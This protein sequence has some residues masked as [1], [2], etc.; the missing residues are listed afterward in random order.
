MEHTNVPLIVVTEAPETPPSVP[1]SAIVIATKLR[2]TAD[3]IYAIFQDFDV[4][5]IRE[6][7]KLMIHNGEFFRMLVEL[8]SNHDTEKAIAIYHLR[9]IERLSVPPFSPDKRVQMILYRT[10]DSQQLRQANIGTVQKQFFPPTE[11]EDDSDS[12]LYDLVV[13]QI[14]NASLVYFHRS[15]RSVVVHFTDEEYQQVMKRKAE[16]PDIMPILHPIP[17]KAQ[18]LFPGVVSPLR[19]PA[20][21]AP[22]E[23][24][25]C[26][27]SGGRLPTVRRRV[28]L[29]LSNSSFSVREHAVA[30]C[31]SVDNSVNSAGR[32]SIFLALW[33]TILRYS[34]PFNEFERFVL[35]SIREECG[36]LSLAEEC[37]TNRSVRSDFEAALVRV[38]EL[39]R[40]LATMKENSKRQEHQ[41]SL[42]EQDLRQEIELLHQSNIEM[43]RL[44]DEA[45]KEHQASLEDL[46]KRLIRE[47]QAHQH[48][49][50]THKRIVG[51]VSDALAKVD[52]LQS[53][54]K[55]REAVLFSERVA[56][57]ETMMHLDEALEDAWTL[58]AEKLERSTQ[59]HSL[60]EN[61]EHLEEALLLMK[62]DMT[63]L[64]SE[65]A[66]ER[67]NCAEN[68]ERAADALLKIETLDA[69]LKESEVKLDSERHAHVEVLKRLLDAVDE[70]KLLEKCVQTRDAQLESERQRTRSKLAN[71]SRLKGLWDVESEVCSCDKVKSTEDPA[72]PCVELK[73]DLSPA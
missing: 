34:D 4:L 54:A 65:L 42:A 45:A 51:D 69:D 59:R 66:L 47:S 52:T 10:D 71:L 70:I 26:E 5:N 40:E 55:E 27:S 57:A 43:Q 20:S 7:E 33:I 31:R 24:E 14:G 46:R 3:D 22:L 67:W 38:K 62:D 28:S 53:E 44:I 13:S 29:N 56:A 17:G 25:R 15:L 60:E 11:N 19:L 50:Q 37:P 9:L 18:T 48:L 72:E 58:E 1:P 61:A 64:E 2:V 41:H 68:A 36:E 8:P 32:V 12:A 16:N 63:L 6:M 39:E 49:L 73:E 35:P 23:P 30:G 21:L